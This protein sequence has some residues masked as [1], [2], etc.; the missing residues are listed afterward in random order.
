VCVCV[1]TWEGLKRSVC[2]NID[3]SRQSVTEKFDIEQ[4]EAS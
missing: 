3:V 4:D 1:C 2:E